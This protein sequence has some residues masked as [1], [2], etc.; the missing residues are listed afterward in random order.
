MD[1]FG[2]HYSRRAKSKKALDLF[3]NDFDGI[4]NA[5]IDVFHLWFTLVFL[6]D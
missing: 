5:L 2:F 3:I 4:K 1:G 6:V